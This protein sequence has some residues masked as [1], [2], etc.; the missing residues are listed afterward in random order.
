MSDRIVELSADI[1]ALESHYTRLVAEHGA[2]PESAQWRDKET[3]EKRMTVLAET[4][5]LRASHVLD[6]GCGTGHMLNVLR[7]RF[8]FDGSYVGYDLAENA[9]ALARAAHTGSAA[10]PPPRFERRDVLADGVGEPF[11]YVFVSGVFNNKVSD[12]WAFMTRILERLFAGT[13][14]ALAFNGLSTYV[15]RFDAGLFYADPGDVFRFCKERLSPRVTL[16][17]DYEVRAGVVPFEY[18]IYVHATDVACRP[19]RAPSSGAAERA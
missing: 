8:A 10:Q 2:A 5:D 4:F 16:R 11:D 19:N 15:D 7:S 13:R 17:H 18:T 14:R 3:Q 9:L 12:N 6:F 1:A